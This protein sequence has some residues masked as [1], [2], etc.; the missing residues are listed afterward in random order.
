MNRRHEKKRLEKEERIAASLKL[1]ENEILSYFSSSNV[2]KIDEY[3]T[4]CDIYADLDTNPSNSGAIIASVDKSTVLSHT[5]LIDWSSLP[6]CVDPAAGDLDPTR[7]RRKREQCLSLVICVE[8]ELQRISRGR[9]GKLEGQVVEF[10]SG[11][12]HLGILLAYRNPSLEIILIER[13]EYSVEQAKARVA[14]AGLSNISIYSGDIDMFATT[15][16][17]F[18][19]LL[20][21]SLHSCGLFTDYIVEF[22]VKNCASFVLVPCCYGQISRPPPDADHSLSLKNRVMSNLQDENILST[23]S[24]GGDYAV[25]SRVDYE[26]SLAFKTAKRCMRVI[27][28]D[29]ILYCLQHQYHCKLSSLH[30]IT[31]SPK[32]NVMIGSH[33]YDSS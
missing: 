33:S 26:G 2:E 25:N 12:G 4:S 22:C 32:N 24:S 5:V 15:Y 29:R 7:A 17:S 16:S 3:L 11:S 31:C 21:I 6:D 28:I 13:K 14:V 20:G 30:P 23:I 19:L 8:E 18:Q 1:C 27:D 9:D 10:G